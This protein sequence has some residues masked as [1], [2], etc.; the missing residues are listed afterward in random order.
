MTEPTLPPVRPD[1]DVLLDIALGTAGESN[2]FDFKQSID[3]SSDEHRVR[4]VR[5]I[6]AFGNTDEGGFVLIG[7]SDDR[8]IVGLA[9]AIADAYDQTRL[10]TIVTQYLAPPPVCQVR[11][12]TRDGRRLVIIE[13]ASF[14]SSPSVVRQSA[15]FGA[16]RLVAGTILYRNSAAESAAL[17]SATDMQSLCA[18]I[19][20]RRASEFVEL[21]QRGGLGQ[22][23]LSAEGSYSQLDSLRQRADEDWPPDRRP[24]VETGFATAT[25]LTLT[26]DQLRALIPGA[27]VRIQHGFPFF[28][29]SGSNVHSPVAWG[30]YGR[31]PF[32]ALGQETEPPS[33]LWLL[34][35]DGAFLD[36]EHLWE[37]DTRSVIVGGVG[38]FHLI[39]RVVL[40]IRFAQN[41]AA[42]LALP[43]T[44]GFRLKV[45]VTGTRGRVLDDERRSFRFPYLAKASEDTVDVSRDVPLRT[46]QASPSDVALALLEELVWQFQRTDLTRHDINTALRAAAEF[47]G[48]EYRL[49]TGA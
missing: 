30:W 27:A 12:H 13:V 18:A 5:A 22:P 15:T 24:F 28:E 8:R 42:T 7:I 23:P 4:L 36:R 1:L 35:R 25:V 21:V 3:L 19:V 17:T 40:L 20:R 29:V 34:S 2:R 32:A 49:D 39:G 45:R 14:T 41:Y 6:G 48:P 10:Q 16:E 46:L 43:S 47:L 33:Y 26:P 9:D 37:D 11:Q 31:I 38:L 44:I